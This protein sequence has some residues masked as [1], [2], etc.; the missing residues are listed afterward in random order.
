MEPLSTSVIS[1]LTL[2]V[3]YGLVKTYFGSA[4][5]TMLPAPVGASIKPPKSNRPKR[6]RNQRRRPTIVIP[7]SPEAQP[8]LELPVE[9]P[10]HEPEPEPM[11]D[12]EP[13]ELPPAEEHEPVGTEVQAEI[14][15]FAERLDREG[16]A[17]GDVQVSLMWN[18]N[19]DLDLSVI[20]PSG[21]RISFDNRFSQCSGRLDVDMNES[22]TSAEPIENVFWPRGQAPVGNYRVFVEHFEKHEMDDE[23]EFRILVRSNDGN[24]EFQGVISNRDPPLE[25]CQFE[26]TPSE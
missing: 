9:E 6:S 19:N 20:C 10:D 1:V 15:D 16:A 4:S 24:R 14:D 13:I 3:A 26:V 2:L 8:E 17:T 7:E 25:V 12:P 11:P 18:N 21:E 23:T 22:E 5:R